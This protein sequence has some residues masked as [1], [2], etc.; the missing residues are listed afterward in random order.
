M[1]GNFKLRSKVEGPVCISKA[2]KN[3]TNK[4]SNQLIQTEMA[5]RIQTEANEDYKNSKDSVQAAIKRI[6]LN[7]KNPLAD[8]KSLL[9]EGEKIGTNPHY[10]DMKG[11]FSS[12][13]IKTS[14]RIKSIVANEKKTKEQSSRPVQTLAT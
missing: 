4:V 6:H 9:N 11:N 5:R 13:S 12:S 1:L 10:T 3:S 7:S 2:L 8:N 14:N